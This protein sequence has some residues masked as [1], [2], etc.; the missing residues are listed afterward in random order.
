MGLRRFT[1]A[2]HAHGHRLLSIGDN[3]SSILGF[4]KGEA[5]D[6]ALRR[7]TRSSAARQIACEVRHF[8][9]YSESERSPTGADSRAVEWDAANMAT[10]FDGLV[11]LHARC[12]QLDGKFILTDFFFVAR[13]CLALLG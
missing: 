3:L 13:I 8:H 11:F 12:Y 6:Y 4:E 5:R 7:L 9:R 10:E 2:V 1:R